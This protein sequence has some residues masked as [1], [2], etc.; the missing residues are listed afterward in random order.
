TEAGDHEKVVGLVYVEAFAPDV[1]ESVFG[2]IPQDPKNPPPFDVSKDGFVF[3]NEAAY[4]PGFADSLP[5]ADAEFLSDSQGPIAFKEP[6][7][8]PLP[9]A[10][11]KTKPSW[12]QMADADHVI[13]PEAQKLMSGRAGATVETVSGGHLAFIAHADATAKLIETAA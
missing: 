1:G 11:W 13:P 3:F 12:Y 10:A 9:V 7:L 8:W 6:G 4:V 5:P 2:L